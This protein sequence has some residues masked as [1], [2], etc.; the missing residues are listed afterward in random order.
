MDNRPCGAEVRRHARAR[1]T[2]SIVGREPELARLE[3]LL[4]PGTDRARVVLIDGE[5]GMGKTT[6][7][8]A[9]IE[10]ARERRWRVLDIRPTDAD[11]IFA[12]AGLGDLF[13]SVADEALAGLP[14][15]QRRALRVALLRA[16]PEG[17]NPDA[18]AVAVAC[19]NT[20][21][22]LSV[23]NPVIVAI[24]DIQWLDPPS[25]Q[26]LGFAI[27]RLHDASILFLLARRI[28][29]RA[30]LSSGLD[31][32]LVGLPHERIEVGPIEPDA[33]RRLLAARLDHAFAG[34]TLRRITVTSGGNPLFAIELGRAILTAP[35]SEEA[36]SDVPI[37][38]TLLDLVGAPIS[39]LPGPTQGALAVVAALAAPTMEL[40]SDAIG[41]SSE[42][43]LLPAV[44]AHVV[45]L[46][47]DRI[48]F[49]HPLQAE[50]V[51]TRL[52]VAERRQI[53]A[54]LAEIV[55]DPEQRARH[56]A[57]ATI[58][59]DETVA[60]TLE[61]AATRARARGAPD[62]AA[63]LAGMARRLTPADRT[64]DVAR[65]GLLEASECLVVG[66][67][68]R[69]RDLVEGMLSGPM[70]PE[71]RWTARHYLAII[72]CWAFDLHAGV[73]LYRQAIADIGADDAQRLPW[74]GGFTGALD[75]LGDD[76]RE[77]LAHGYAELELAERLGDESRAVTALRGIARNEQRLTGRMPVELI[78]RAL[79]REWIVRENREVAAWPT[80]CLAD[81]L[82]WT[83]DLEQGLAAWNRLLNEAAARGETHSLIDI[84]YRAIIC[85]CAAGLF[86]QAQAHADEGCELA[87]DRGATVFE[88]ILVADRALVEAHRGDEEAARRD[89]AEAIR[90]AAMGNPQA[91]RIAA[92]ALGLLELS[93]DDPAAAHEHLGPLVASRRSAG[94]A[95]PGEMRFVTDEIEALIGIGR[96]DDAEA[97]LGWYEGLAEASGR[98]GALAAC[99]RCRG[100][101][102]VAHGD[103]DAA[104]DS[105]GR[106]VERYEG[107]TEPL[108]LARTLLV[109]GAIERR[110]LHKR[111][112][113]E[114]L[115]AALARFEVLGARLWAQA[116]REELGRIGGRAASPDA[117]TPSE[118]RVATLVAEGRTNREVAASLVLAERTVEG[119]LSN[120]YAKLGVRSR[121]ELAHRLTRGTEPR[122]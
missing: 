102:Q 71:Q 110:R 12:Y 103:I 14:S 74:E 20:L 51:R 42:G 107:R 87:N 54:R 91:D 8:S 99:D 5:P 116:A 10:S 119:H 39:A 118:R 88:A 84:L 4:E 48:R 17:P 56:L 55:P 76:Y 36:G 64:E 67:Y 52:S 86:D 72:T 105:L 80:F 2:R 120:I 83:D 92:W 112:A 19:L 100:L 25:A 95:E 90:L 96:L 94:V 34:P 60:A 40:V 45:V 13:E 6:L 85:E 93:L 26:A 58:R 111:V 61:D 109:L 35:A 11:A 115:G 7:W 47:G 32:A 101:L 30:E 37:P 18:R 68:G 16:E 53:H 43:P 3:A 22:S 98:I 15:P 21:R 33:M 69:V 9:A 28:D 27:R 59:P 65:R 97:M 81:M 62:A 113:R 29:D 63:E 122:A 44:D 108:G 31:R 78:D 46:E 38:S 121:A 50:A 117:L 75:L 79:E 23:E 104:V 114:T 1:V 106:S 77:A 82:S 24:D 57:L 73:A 41:V 66:E 70:A 49:S 89:A